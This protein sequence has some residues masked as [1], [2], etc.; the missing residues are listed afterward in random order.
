MQKAPHFQAVYELGAD[1]AEAEH[2]GVAPP[3]DRHAPGDRLWARIMG[4]ENR[5]DWPT[6]TLPQL[7]A[8]LNKGYAD[9]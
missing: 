4:E 9:Y 3:F 2:D 1:I 6:N 5:A 7:R 8:E